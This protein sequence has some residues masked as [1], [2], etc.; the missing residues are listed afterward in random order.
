MQG[1]NTDHV[2]GV[3]QCQLPYPFVPSTPSTTEK[4]VEKTFNKIAAND[5]QE[6]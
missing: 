4:S 6:L 5:I 3:G 2:V 1:S